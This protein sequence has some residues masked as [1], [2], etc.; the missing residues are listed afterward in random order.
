MDKMTCKLANNQDLEVQ[1]REKNQQAR[2]PTKEKKNIWLKKSA[3]HWKEVTRNLSLS[4]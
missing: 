2:L 3:N 4:T 1:F